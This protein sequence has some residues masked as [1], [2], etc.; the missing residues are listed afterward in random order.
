[1]HSAAVATYE[2]GDV[3]ADDSPPMGRNLLARSPPPRAPRPA[4]VPKDGPYEYAAGFEPK[5]H[6]PTD[7][8]RRAAMGL[9]PD[10]PPPQRVIRS[11]ETVAGV[12]DAKS[13]EMQHLDD[14][15]P[16]AAAAAA[17]TSLR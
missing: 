13:R 4:A 16:D 11:P 12:L 15:E 10:D 17:T 7:A 14:D 9:P 3:G 2:V 1:M 5:H 6:H 8:E